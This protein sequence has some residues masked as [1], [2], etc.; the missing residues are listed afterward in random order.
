MLEG[1]SFFLILQPTLVFALFPLIC[2]DWKLLDLFLKKFDNLV[3]SDA[4]NCK[5]MS[6]RQTG[7]MKIFFLIIYFLEVLFIFRRTKN[8]SVFSNNFLT[9]SLS[10]QF[11]TNSWLTQI[12]IVETNPSFYNLKSIVVLESVSQSVRSIQNDVNKNIEMFCI[13][14]VVTNVCVFSY[15]ISSKSKSP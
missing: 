12:F 13:Y 11:C 15:K 14:L 6:S 5:K 3:N 8:P 10:N 7:A 4:S 9:I 2:G 1:S